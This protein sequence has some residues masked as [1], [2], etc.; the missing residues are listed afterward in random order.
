MLEHHDGSHSPLRLR[1]VGQAFRL[2]CAK[3]TAIP[4]SALWANIVVSDRATALPYGWRANMVVRGG[5]LALETSGHGG[6]QLTFLGGGNKGG[7]GSC[8]AR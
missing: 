6:T 5:I 7:A 1:A 4:T 8:M 2:V 3:A